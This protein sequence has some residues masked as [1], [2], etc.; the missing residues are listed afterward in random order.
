M[1]VMAEF[2][3]PAA[4]FV[5]AETLTATPDMRIE[6]KRVVGGSGLVTPYFWAAGGDFETFERALR[7]DETIRDVLT[8]EEYADG[9]TDDERFYRVTWEAGLPNLITAVADAKATVLEATSS[10]GQRWRVTVLFPSEGR[11]SEFHD[12]CLDH[13]FTVQ[14]ERIYRP[15]NPQERGQYDVTED[16]QEALEAA[17]RAGYFEVPRE[18]TLVELAADIGISQNALSARLR[19]GTANVL[20]NTIIHEQ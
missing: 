7:D 15:E 2:T 12:Y 10:D 16:Q 3:V 20:E 9:E 5:L 8:L 18:T 6:I 13:E 19:R 1:S 17:F 11:L 4:E 14:P